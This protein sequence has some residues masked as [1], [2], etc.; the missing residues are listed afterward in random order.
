MSCEYDYHCRAL[1]WNVGGAAIH[2]INANKFRTFRR[3]GA[4]GILCLQETR[5]SQ[6]GDASMQQRLNRMQVV[7]TPASVTDAGGMSGGAAMLVPLGFS[8]LKHVVI[9]VNRI[10]AVLLQSRT[11]T[12]W[13]VNCYFHPLEK[14]ESLLALKSWVTSDAGAEY[15]IIMCG[16]FNP[17]ENTHKDL[18]V[19]VLQNADLH[20]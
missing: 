17:A 13:V 16:D 10:H 19:Q 9:Q 20:D 14:R 1:T 11:V 3:L 8:L 4:Q 2:R 5:W 7:H 15:Q 18:W 6:S 12:F